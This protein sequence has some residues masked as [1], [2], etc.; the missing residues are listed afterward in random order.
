M[1]YIAIFAYN[2]G[3]FD[4]Y[5]LNR[6]SNDTNYIF[7][8]RPEKMLG[9]CFDGHEVIGNFWDR[10][11]ASDLYDEWLRRYPYHSELDQDKN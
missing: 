7:I 1:R 4:E 8:S 3:Q 10:E 5:V 6:Q 9:T 11:G 2:H